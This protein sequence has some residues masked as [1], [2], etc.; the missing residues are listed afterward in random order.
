MKRYLVVAMGMLAVL[1][2]VA[3]AVAGHRLRARLHLGRANCPPSPTVWV[4]G[5]PYAPPLTPG[6]GA[7]CQGSG[8]STPPSDGSGDVRDGK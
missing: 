1:A 6:V 8:E 5:V 7:A 3:P 4:D 2:M